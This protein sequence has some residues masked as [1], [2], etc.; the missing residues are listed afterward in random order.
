MALP[1]AVAELVAA[2]RRNSIHIAT[3][4]PIGFLVRRYCRKHGLPFA[5]SFHTRFPEYVSARAALVP[6]CEPGGDGG[7]PGSGW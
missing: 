4:G 2:S 7:D 5:T 3:E 6:P 1:R